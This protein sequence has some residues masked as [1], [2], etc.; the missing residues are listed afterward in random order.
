MPSATC[1]GETTVEHCKSY[2]HDVP[3]V[4]ELD[5]ASLGDVPLFTADTDGR[6]TG[7]TI[8]HDAC[9]LEIVCLSVACG[10]D[11]TA[12]SVVRACG[13]PKE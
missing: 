10:V 1:D 4:C 8:R 2:S 5:A 13:L 3:V 12:A 11:V 7:A 6:K 9:P